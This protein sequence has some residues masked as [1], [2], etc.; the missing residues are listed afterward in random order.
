[1]SETFGTVFYRRHHHRLEDW[2]GTPVIWCGGSCAMDS[3][4]PAAGSWRR[5]SRVHY[6]RR[7]AAAAQLA[8]VRDQARSK[9]YGHSSPSRGESRCTAILGAD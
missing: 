7:G 9:T 3:D 8:A 1:M 4:A 5:I 2:G 6:D